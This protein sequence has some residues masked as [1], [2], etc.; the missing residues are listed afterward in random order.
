[1]QIGDR[2]FFMAWAVVEANPRVEKSEFPWLARGRGELQGRP[3]ACPSP[4]RCACARPSISGA[5]ARAR[6][7][8]NEETLATHPDPRQRK[9]PD[10]RQ[11]SRRVTDV[12]DPTQSAT[13]TMKLRANRILS[14]GVLVLL[15]LVLLSTQVQAESEHFEAEPTRV[16]QGLPLYPPPSH[17][18]L[19]GRRSLLGHRDEPRFCCRAFTAQCLA[20]NAGMSV[21]EFCKKRRNKD[22][23]G[24]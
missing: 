12:T 24:C 21:R 22:I 10:P 3:R 1:M 18:W 2:F 16:L 15:G 20:C 23:S 6:A 4:T 7:S 5:S 11:R 13:Y 17:G 19:G 8:E 9:N 14:V